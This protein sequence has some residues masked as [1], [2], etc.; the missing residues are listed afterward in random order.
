MRSCRAALVVASALGMRLSAQ[1][2]AKRVTASDGI[3][4]VIY[5]SRSSACGDGR[6]FIQNV[7][8]DIRYDSGDATW[9]SRNG[10]NVVNCVHGPA[11]VAATVIDGEVTRL[12]LYVGPVRD[13]PADARSITV[14]AAEAAD[15]LGGLVSRG[16]SRVASSA[17]LPLVTA[18][19]PDPWPLL[20]RVARD[21]GRPRDVRKSSLTW[22]SFGVTNHLGLSNVDERGSDDDDL[23]SQAVF[24]LSQRPKSE[25]VPEL[26]DLAKTA[27]HPA[28]RKAAIF[29]LGQ[30]GDLRAADV[31]AEL[32]GIR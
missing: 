19:A 26:I 23:R 24:V 2:L 3:V 15:W 29:W 16:Q 20:L 22:L 1:D 21:D 18:D 11:R 12:R 17:I 5:P 13:L 30:S 8:G 10:A 28:A 25:S 31:Y 9:A 7:L 6:S 14:T 32:L 27:K 4:N